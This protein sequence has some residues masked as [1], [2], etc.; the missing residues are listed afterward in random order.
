[1][2]QRSLPIAMEGHPHVLVGI[3]QRKAA[4]PGGFK[5]VLLPSPMLAP[6]VS[7]NGVR[8]DLVAFGCNAEEGRL[9]IDVDAG[10]ED[11]PEEEAMEE[12]E[13]QTGVGEKTPSEV[14]GH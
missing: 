4:V 6:S 8:V 3:P 12:K 10:I 13:N 9:I 5:L 14:A 11:F 2:Q 7:L 1:M